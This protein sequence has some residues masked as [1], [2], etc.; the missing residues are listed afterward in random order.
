MPPLA[1]ERSGLAM[2]AVVGADLAREM[3]KVAV[4]ER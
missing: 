2:A 3:H 4:E 1:A